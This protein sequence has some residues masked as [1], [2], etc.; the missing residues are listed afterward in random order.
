MIFR[1]EPGFADVSI[2]E[3]VFLD[4]I[5]FYT[6][7]YYSKEVCCANGFESSGFDVPGGENYGVVIVI[8]D[9]K[10]DGIRS[11]PFVVER[12]MSGYNS[13]YPVLRIAKIDG[14]EPYGMRVF[15]PESSSEFFNTHEQYLGEEMYWWPEYVDSE[16]SE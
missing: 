2:D 13:D 10:P 12:V 14:K 9:E 3:D 4:D 5:T 1:T 8:S 11:V 7:N 6:D 15:L 16:D